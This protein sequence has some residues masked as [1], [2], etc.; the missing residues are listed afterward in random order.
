MVSSL[1]TLRLCDGRFKAPPAVCSSKAHLYSRVARKACGTSRLLPL[2]E[3]LTQ[4][5]FL[6]GEGYNVSAGCRKRSG[7]TSQASRSQ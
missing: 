5:K 3:R 1:C 2:P 7:Q 4:K 6:R